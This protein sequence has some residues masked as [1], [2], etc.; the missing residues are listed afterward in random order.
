MWRQFL[1]TVSVASQMVVQ[2]VLTQLPAALVNIRG[3]QGM[4]HCVLALK[5]T[6]MMAYQPNVE[7]IVDTIIAVLF[8][9]LENA[10]E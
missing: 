3:R 5:D 2:L 9:F 4:D 6:L 7:V 8:L 1:T 10:S